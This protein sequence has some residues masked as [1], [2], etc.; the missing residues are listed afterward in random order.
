M[1]KSL[2]AD[3]FNRF[4]H[5]KN[6]DI[7]LQRISHTYTKFILA[8]QRKDSLYGSM[9]EGHGLGNV[10][11]TPCDATIDIDSENDDVEDVSRLYDYSSNNEKGK[12]C[13]SDTPNIPAKTLEYQTV[14]QPLGY[15][16]PPEYH[17]EESSSKSDDRSSSDSGVSRSKSRS[18]EE[19][20]IQ[21]GIELPALHRNKQLN[22]TVV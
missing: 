21:Q 9:D 15:E 20:Y 22:T 13:K 1:V 18:R 5:T 3:S 4:N 17:Y 2:L 7:Y 8:K 11:R 14:S 6:Y 12:C 10:T 16:L 19:D